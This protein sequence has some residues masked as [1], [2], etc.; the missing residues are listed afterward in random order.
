MPQL[1][2]WLEKD[3]F[4]SRPQDKLL[5]L[6]DARRTVTYLGWPG[7]SNPAAAQVYVLRTISNMMA[8]VAKGEA[9]AEEAVAAAEA[10]INEVFADWRDRG[11]VGCG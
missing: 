8:T 1:Q 10:Q 11:F 3:P 4:G 7:P 5:V 2:S 6:N 9:T